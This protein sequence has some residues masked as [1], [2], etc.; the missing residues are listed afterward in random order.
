MIDRSDTQARLRLF[1]YGLI[2]IVVVTFL[3][4]LMA[5]VAILRTTGLPLPP[6]TDFLGTALLFTVVVAIIAGLAY[7][8]YSYFLTK[9]MPF[10]SQ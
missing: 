1:R 8:A 4:S 2:A 3:I 10:G 6:I 7:V 5:P 9:K